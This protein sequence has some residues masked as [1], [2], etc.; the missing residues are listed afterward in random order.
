[1]F[2]DDT[3]LLYAVE[4]MKTLFDTVNNELQKVS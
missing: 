4:N 3:N 1:M 2:V